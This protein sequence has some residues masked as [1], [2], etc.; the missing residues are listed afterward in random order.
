[1]RV[2][3]AIVFFAATV[4]F[5]AYAV[6]AGDDPTLIYS[7]DELSNIS[8]SG[9]YALASDIF[10]T[11]EWTPIAV[12]RGSFDGAGFEIRGATSAIFAKL[13]GAEIR[14]LTLCDAKIYVGGE[15][16]RS[17]F[18]AGLLANEVTGGI[19]ENIEVYGVEIFAAAVDAGNGTVGGLVGAVRDADIKNIRMYDVRI[20]ET[21]RAAEANDSPKGERGCA[22]LRA[23][24]GL[25]GILQNCT[26]EDAIVLNAEIG[27]DALASGGF[28][29]I[30]RGN[31]VFEDCHVAADMYANVSGG[32]IYGG[33]AGR[34]DGNSSSVGAEFTRCRATGSIQATTAGGFVGLLSG[35]SR[36]IHSHANSTVFA[37]NAGGFAGEI[38]NASRIEF[39]SATS[40]VFGAEN[41]GGFVGIISDTDAPNTITNSLALG[42]VVSSESGTARRFAARLDHDGIN[43][44]YAALGMTIIRGNNLAHAIP[45]PFSADG[46]DIALSRIYKYIANPG[47]G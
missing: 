31:A 1:M 13:D 14:G 5:S 37:N 30:V 15:I 26:V 34:T 3:F 38:T 35:R 28:V 24:G 21:S 12:F 32:G 39:S 29:G 42:S 8:V 17:E 25:A 43:N 22:P 23:V 40:A 4:V 46:G 9:D 11:G 20:S 10:L 45:N 7:R 18:A 44:C 2:G 27:A 47:D 36:I 33:F 19:I 6:S 16:K 41:A